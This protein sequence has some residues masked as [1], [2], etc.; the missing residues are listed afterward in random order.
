MLAA[1]GDTHLHL[2]PQLLTYATGLI[3]PLVVGLVTKWHAS[4]GLKAWAN[5]ILSV[6]AGA[7]NVALTSNGDVLLSA[8][9]TGIVQT[10][11]VSVASYYGF[12]KPTGIAQTVQL[13]AP[14]VGI[15]PALP[16]LALS[17]DD[18]LPGPATT[19]DSVPEPPDAE[20]APVTPGPKKAAVKKTSR[21]KSAK[22]KR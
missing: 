7:L 14:S 2:N 9:V 20:L 15:G 3:I 10:L 16:P 13:V 11:V 1:V 8:W 6:I 12:W 4:S 5:V 19:D 22:S 17:P 21:P 18:I